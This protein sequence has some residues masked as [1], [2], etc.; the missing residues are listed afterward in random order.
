MTA[1]LKRN[2]PL[3]FTPGIWWWNVKWNTAM[4][5]SRLGYQ[6]YCLNRGLWR[7]SSQVI[8]EKARG[9]VVSVLPPESGYWLLSD[10][11]TAGKMTFNTPGISVTVTHA[12]S[13]RR[14]DSVTWLARSS[15]VLRAGTPGAVRWLLG[16]PEGRRLSIDSSS[17]REPGAGSATCP[18]CACAAPGWQ[19]LPA[20]ASLLFSVGCR[21]SAGRSRLLQSDFQ[22]SPLKPSRGRWGAGKNAVLSLR[23]DAPPFLLLASVELLAPSLRFQRSS[24]TSSFVLSQTPNSVFPIPIRAVVMSQP[25]IPVSGGAP[26]S[27]QAQNGAASASGSLYS[28]GK[29]SPGAGGWRSPGPS[30]SWPLVTAASCLWRGGWPPGRG[31]E[32]VIVGS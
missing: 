29:Y 10:P 2:T 24:F 16:S 7:L 8:F 21:L 28:N 18:D 11:G 14:W 20:G 30:S 9:E 32:R 12:T 31:N 1:T 23:L 13:G 5:I 26:A 19:P 22:A 6:K 25:G 15:T 3:Q 4:N 17:S 27:L